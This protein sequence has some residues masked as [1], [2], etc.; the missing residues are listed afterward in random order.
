MWL[1][2]MVLTVAMAGK[3][4]PV[5]DDSLAD[6]LVSKMC[7]LVPPGDYVAGRALMRDSQAARDLID[8]LKLL[9]PLQPT[10]TTTAAKDCLLAAAEGACEESGEVCDDDEVLVPTCA[11][12][13]TM[14]DCLV[15]IHCHCVPGTTDPPETEPEDPPDEVDTGDVLEGAP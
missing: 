14:G 10:C 3:P 7:P 6:D 4:V 9:E 1:W 15:V 13:P 5:V 12:V 2:S 8:L 11:G